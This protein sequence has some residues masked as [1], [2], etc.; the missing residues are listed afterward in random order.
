MFSHRERLGRLQVISTTPSKE[1]GFTFTQYIKNIYVR[2][3]Y[4]IMKKI[5][6]SAAF[7]LLTIALVA[8]TQTVDLRDQLTKKELGFQMDGTFPPQAVR[9]PWAIYR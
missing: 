8:Q 1:G 7:S 9:C 5:Y 6:L 3:K 4:I 2:K